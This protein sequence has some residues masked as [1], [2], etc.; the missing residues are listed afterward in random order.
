M[1]GLQQALMILQNKANPI[2]DQAKTIL[3]NIPATMYSNHYNQ[4]QQNV[5]NAKDLMAGVS[6]PYADGNPDQTFTPKGAGQF[7]GGS[8]VG[9]EI[10]ALA[11]AIKLVKAPKTIQE[12]R[13]L[14]P[15]TKALQES[16]L[17]DSVGQARKAFNMIP[18][19]NYIVQP[20]REIL[21]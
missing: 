6:Q 2:I 9:P 4:L 10:G 3:G 8:P 17:Y 21:K 7:I 12:I 18:R 13:F 20:P 11:G 1:N 19:G 16:R 14:D 15:I 5:Q